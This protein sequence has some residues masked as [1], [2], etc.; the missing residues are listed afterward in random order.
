[1]SELSGVREPMAELK[2][3]KTRHKQMEEQFQTLVDSIPFGLS[4]IGK[5]GTYGY[6]NA[7]FTE[8]FGYTLE[9]VPTGEEWF[10]KAYPDPQYRQ[11]ALTCWLDDLRKL[12]FGEVRHR[13]FVVTCKNGAKKGIQFRAVTLTDG[14]QLVTYEDITERN[15]M[16][17]ALRESEEF[18]SSLLINSPHP[19]VVI[20]PD[21]SI[22]YVN[23][24]LEKL[25]GFS[26]GELI[27]KKIPYPWWTEETLQKITSDYWKAMSGEM[28]RF[29]ELFQKKNGERFW[30]EV[31][32]RR[33][34]SNGEFKH[35][36][37]NWANITER[38][39]AEE[40]LVK[41]SEQLRN[42]SAHLQSAR[43]EERT[44]IGREIHDDLG[45]ALT[46]LKMDICWLGKRLTKS[47]ESLCEKTESMSRLI[48]VTLQ[49][50]R[51]IS[52]E[53]RP[54]L[55]DDLGLAAA[56]EWQ[57]QEFQKVTG[58]KCK[59]TFDP[60]D[61]TLDH[62]RSTTIFRIFQE[63]LA[64]VFHHAN[65]TRVV[66]SLKKGDN[67]VVLEVS[68]NGKGI[69]PEQISDPKA[70]GLMGVRERAHFWGGVVK[71]SGVRGKGTI[72]MVRIPLSKGEGNKC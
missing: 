42:L 59:V 2:E 11:K 30:V 63:T 43:E 40:Q 23:P 62:E 20:N 57:A 4:L 34:I 51:R 32:A 68:D 60:G 8:M 29:E 46:A 65:A 3:P 26:C 7:K 50:V 14:R 70:F 56:I 38:K 71:I 41:L 55:L 28:E 72:V 44:R 12:E 6:V 16:F 37:S 49:S 24:A 58:I 45:Q 47:Q 27:G 18:S 25:A 1:M 64:N 31:T 36:L 66:A 19:I 54:R 21:T 13:T 35:F 15:Q 67:Q 52:A 48:D 10:E 61:I 17:K 39:R 9:D 69:T 22:R 5:N 53:L 33:V